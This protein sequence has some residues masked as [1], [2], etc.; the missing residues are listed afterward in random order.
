MNTVQKLSHA[1]I[2][3]YLKATGY[4]YLRDS[5]GDFRVDF[6][7]DEKLDSKISYYLVIDGQNRHIY[8][9]R[10]HSDK[11]IP[12][13]DWARFLYLINEWN[14]DK[15]W[16]KAYLYIRDPASSPSGEII[17]EH[18]LPLENGIHQELLNE[19][20]DS[21]LTAAYAFWGWIVEI[22]ASDA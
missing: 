6:S 13:N 1:M 18:Q 10:V 2:E 17:L 11:R 5:D 20:T 16:P 19:F 7:Y 15:R 12:R 9:V 14:R 4:K 3:E 22:Q 21:T 8:T